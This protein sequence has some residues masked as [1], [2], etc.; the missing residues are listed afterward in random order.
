MIWRIIIGIGLGLGLR[1]IAR[2]YRNPGS[3]WE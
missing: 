1:G 3:L 2:R